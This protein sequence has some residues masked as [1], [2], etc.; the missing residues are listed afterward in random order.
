MIQLL[1]QVT[2]DYVP[3]TFDSDK[4]QTVVEPIF[5]G[6]DWLTDERVQGAKRCMSDG[7]LELER[8][9]GIIP[10]SEDFHRSMNHLE[11]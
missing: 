11:V 8:L 3:T 9:E 2:E 6:G 1:K 4:K 10:K 5:F 7:E